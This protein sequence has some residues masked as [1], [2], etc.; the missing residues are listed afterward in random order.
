MQLEDVDFMIAFGFAHANDAVFASSL[1][2]EAA[3][4]VA[5]DV[6]AASAASSAVADAAAFTSAKSPLVTGQLSRDTSAHSPAVALPAAAAAVAVASPA[7]AAAAAAAESSAADA[8]AAAAPMVAQVDHD[9]FV[10][11]T[12]GARLPPVRAAMLTLSS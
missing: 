5:A 4:A 3:V 11:M 10:K 12:V 7:V 1:P 9:A 6:T 8:A 2:P